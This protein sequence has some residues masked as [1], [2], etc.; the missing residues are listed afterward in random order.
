[1]LQPSR[2]TEFCSVLKRDEDQRAVLGV[3]LPSPFSFYFKNGR[4]SF[5]LALPLPLSTLVL[6]SGYPSFPPALVN[7][8]LGRL[9]SGP[10]HS[11]CRLEYTE[12]S[13]V[14][15]LMSVAS[16]LVWVETGGSMGLHDQASWKNPQ[17]PNSVKVASYDDALCFPHTHTCAFIQHIHTLKNY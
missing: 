9:L 10:E 15:M 8:E 12:K 5:A 7:M 14:W 11:P 17:A 13:W 2:V 16:A 3:F 1:M 4:L 6:G